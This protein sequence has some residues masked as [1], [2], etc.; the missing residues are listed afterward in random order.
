MAEKDPAYSGDFLARLFNLTPRRVQQLASDGVIPR[1]SRGKYP[2]VASVQGYTK[3]LQD[4]VTGDRKDG[5]R[6]ERERLAREQADR[7]AI[8]NACTRGELIYAADVQ[9][10]L[11]TAVASLA[12]DLD[13][14]PGRLAST[15]AGMNDPALIRSTI[16]DE[17]RRIRESF[18]AQLAELA[19]PAGAADEGG[20]DGEA[21][22]EA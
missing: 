11:S 9:E 10:A 7:V 15:V 22:P 19:E 3:F 4:R 17:S 18:A 1:V 12:A 21:T 20:A 13:G 8:E 2:L 16:L 14:M 5:W 6:G